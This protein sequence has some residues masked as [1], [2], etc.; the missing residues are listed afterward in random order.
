MAN[1]TQAISFDEFAD[2]LSGY[3]DRVI[4]EGETVLVE[5]EAGEVV[6]LKPVSATRTG[7][8]EKT[9]ADHEAFLA[10]AGSWSDVDID[11]FLNKEVS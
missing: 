9:A 2:N 5:K 3:F 1:E 8:R 11:V 7:R 10:S 6:V 4:R